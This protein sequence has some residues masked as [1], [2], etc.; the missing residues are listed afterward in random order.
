M[1]GLEQD[2]KLLLVVFTEESLMYFRQD[3][4]SAGESSTG[5][6]FTLFFIYTNRV[7]PEAAE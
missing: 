1:K 7:E 3:S 5:Q 6:F 4:A 2:D